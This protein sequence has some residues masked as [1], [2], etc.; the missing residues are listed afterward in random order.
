MH[1]YYLCLLFTA[2]FSP[3]LSAAENTTFSRLDKVAH[4]DALR[5]CIWPDY[6]SIT[7]RNPKTQQLSGIDIDMA[8][9]LGKDLGVAVHFIDS[10]FATLIDDITQDHCDIAMFAVGITLARKTKLR[11]SQPNLISGVFGIT[12]KSNRRITQ[13]SDID[14]PDSVVAVAKGT[15]HE[16]VMKEKLKSA[17]LLIL[18]T[19]FAREQEVQSGRADV[20]MTDFPYSQQFL[21]KSDWA[22]RVSP[23][24]NYPKTPYAYAMQPGDDDWHNRIEKFVRDIKKD[25]RL[26]TSAKRHHLEAIIVP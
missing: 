23:P 13:W 21:T 19:P 15:L 16:A 26:L 1:I 12:T 8:N 9:A 25:G 24:N 11:F 7:Y 5:V 22:R 14:K 18:N 4:A 3:W 20:F 17:Q 10:S 6:Y 2:L